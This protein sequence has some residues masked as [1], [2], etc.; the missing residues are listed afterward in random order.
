M[1]PSLT[2]QRFAPGGE[3]S[4]P[5]TL[6]LPGP[7]WPTE[8][9]HT[10]AKPNLKRFLRLFLAFLDILCLFGLGQGREPW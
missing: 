9:D 6:P 2:K 7:L 10:G 3:S 1:A 8:P 5:A 4:P